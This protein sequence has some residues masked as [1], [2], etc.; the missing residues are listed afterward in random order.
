MN[1]HTE[2]EL[3]ELEALPDTNLS[4]AEELAVMLDLR[5]AYVRDFTIFRANA[6]INRAV[7]NP[8]RADEFQKNAEM[9]LKAIG[10]LDKDI[11]RLKGALR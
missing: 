11:E 6:R 4:P 9:T 1:S 5:K 2:L 7:D 8:Q 3:P 10:I